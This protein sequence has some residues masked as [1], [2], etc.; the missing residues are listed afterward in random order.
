MFVC[1]EQGANDLHVVQLM[2]LPL[3]VIS[4][5]LHCFKGH[6]QKMRNKRESTFGLDQST[7]VAEL[8]VGHIR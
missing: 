8:W 7:I 5:L 6:L 3:F 2:P 4:R 1:L